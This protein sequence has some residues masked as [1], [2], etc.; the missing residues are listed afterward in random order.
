[1]WSEGA[2]LAFSQ[3]QDAKNS[4]DLLRGCNVTACWQ[5]QSKVFDSMNSK[6][7]LLHPGPSVGI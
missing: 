3:A 5:I 2:S 4:K 1:M 7:A 6:E